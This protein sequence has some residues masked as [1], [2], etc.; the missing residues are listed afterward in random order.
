[1][2]TVR[3]CN[4]CKQD[5]EENMV[6]FNGFC[7]MCGSMTIRVRMPNEPV[8]QMEQTDKSFYDFE[9]TQ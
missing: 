8:A 2:R 7:L 9:V 1:M 6:E 3:H 5:L 4:F